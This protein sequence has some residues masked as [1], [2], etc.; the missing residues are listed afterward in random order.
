M[1]ALTIYGDLQATCTQRVLVL[2]E[3]LELKY[4][5]VPVDLSKGEQKSKQHLLLQPFGKV[6]VMQYGDRTLF[7]SRTILRYISKNNREELDLF[8]DIMTDMWLESESHN[9]NPPLSKIMYEK[10]FKKWFGKEADQSI[11]DN[12]TENFKKV[13]E[14]YDA[15]LENNEY[16]NG[17]FYSIADISHIPY[18]YL[19]LKNG[20]KNLFKQYPNVY[21]WLKRILK[22]PAVQTV[23]EN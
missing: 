15:H 21:N 2:L 3:E 7:E 9:Y 16:L 14:V 13:L 23:L 4:N 11:I 22:R 19:A 6:P 8:G 17:E 18:S 10:V 20:Y 1:V 12:E 5:F